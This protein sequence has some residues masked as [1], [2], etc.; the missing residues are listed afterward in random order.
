M[1]VK[2]NNE[3]PVTPAKEQQVNYIET[4]DL[5]AIKKHG[6][7]RFVNLTGASENLLPRDS[8]VSLRHFELANKLANQLKLEAKW[9][10]AATPDQAVEMVIAGEADIIAYNLT[11]TDA[12]EK[13]IDFA[14]PIRHSR[15]QLVTGPSGPDIS[16]PSK[17]KDVELI[18]PQ[19]SAN[20]ETAKE[21]IAKYPDANLTVKEFVVYGNRDGLVDMLNQGKNRVAILED[22]S[23]EGLRNYRDDLRLGAY[24]SEVQNIAWG[25]RKDAKRLHSTVDNFL[26][27]NLVKAQEERITDWKG[28]KKSGVIRLLTYNGP[29]TYFLWKGLLMGF[30]YDLAKAFADKHKLQLQIIVVPYEEDLAD[31]LRAGRGDFAGAELNITSSYEAK[32]MVFTKPYVESADQVISNKDKPPIEQIQDLNG[33]KLTL[34][35]YSSFI[36]SAKTLRDAGINV[37]I[38]VAPP[39]MSQSQIFSLIEDGL[40]DATIAHSGRAKIEA[41]VQPNLVLGTLLGDPQ[42][43]GWLV[44]RQN[45]HLLKNLNKFIQDYRKTAKYKKQ[46]AAYFEPNKRFMQRVSS[47]VIPGENLSPYDDLVKESAFKYDFDWRMIVAQMWQESNFNP[48]AVSPVGAQGLMQ[49]MPATA[50]EMGFPP[51]LFEPERGIKAGVKYMDWV[52]D[53]FN[54]SLPTVNKLWFTLASYNAGYGHLL[55][56]QRL[57]KQL[58]L[59]PNIWFDNVEVAMLKLA[60]PQYFKRARYGY[61]RG[62]EPVQYVRNIS[63]LYKAYVEMMSD[64]VSA[65]SPINRSPDNTYCSPQNTPEGVIKQIPKYSAP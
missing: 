4:G 23:A 64:D 11:V 16:D 43:Q 65:V 21:L 6:T 22:F 50:E 38:Q 53:R 61:V 41:S 56:A 29:T 10:K 7:I 18:V 45:W 47:R 58:G 62:S 46:Y 19:G 44:L 42:P 49:V 24:V 25:L 34:R 30:D 20:I 3:T 51:P 13:I 35:A 27:R 31:W 8:V 1:P 54:P 5:K 57:A 12:R 15:Q 48:K 40:I 32:G 59:D 14:V 2:R 60:Q 36:D 28:I 9:I 17:L 33:R 55:D 52:R 26:T 37:E 63:N 39:D